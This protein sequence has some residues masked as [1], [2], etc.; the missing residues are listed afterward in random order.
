[1]FC[2]S[3]R[4]H[5]RIIQNSW[6]RV[7][8]DRFIYFKVTNLSTLNFLL[9]LMYILLVFKVYDEIAPGLA[10]KVFESLKVFK[11]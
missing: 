8:L 1:M 7:F 2:Q 5:F 6:E 4:L 9:I 11:H 3:K 10:L